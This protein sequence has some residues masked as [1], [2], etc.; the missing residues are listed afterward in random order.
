MIVGVERSY[1]ANLA[2]IFLHPL[3]HDNAHNA[4]D[5][6]PTEGATPVPIPE[7][8][9][10]S[11]A[12]PAVAALEQHGVLW[13]LHA[14]EAHV[15]TRASVRRDEIRIVPNDENTSYVVDHGFRGRNWIFYLHSFI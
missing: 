11:Y 3:R 5:L 2:A 9:G 7:T 14:Y 10:A 8:A 4:G 12:Q 6:L 15:L 13:L 1:G